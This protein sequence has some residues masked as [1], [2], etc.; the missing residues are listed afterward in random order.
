[1]P[2]LTK[3]HLKRMQA[4]DGLPV[5]TLPS[6]RGVPGYGLARVAASGCSY[7]ATR[8]SAT[9]SSVTAKRP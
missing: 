9:C 4:A 7:A 5:L 2:S 8:G 3:P 6:A 1:M